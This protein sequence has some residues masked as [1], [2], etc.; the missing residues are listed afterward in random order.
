MVPDV[1]CRR[2]LA[3]GDLL[4]ISDTI[5]NIYISN[6]YLNEYLKYL[7]FLMNNTIN[8]YGMVDN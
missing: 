3:F 8:H 5:L 1:S 4:R 6:E 2:V 7:I